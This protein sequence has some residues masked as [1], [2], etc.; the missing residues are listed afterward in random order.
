MLW[1]MDVGILNAGECYK[2]LG[3]GVSTY[4]GRKYLSVGR[5]CKI[6]KIGEVIEDS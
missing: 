2:L 4:D 6:E 1:E 5:E 3:V